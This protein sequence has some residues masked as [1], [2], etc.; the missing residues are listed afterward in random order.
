MGETS[1]SKWPFTSWLIQIGVILTTYYPWDD[2]PS[3]QQRREGPTH[4]TPFHGFHGGNSYCWWKKSIRRSPVEV[5]RLSHF[6][7]G[8]STIPGGCLGLLK[9]QPYH[10]DLQ[11]PGQR[12]STTLWNSLHDR[13]GPNSGLQIHPRRLTAGTWKWWALEDDFPLPGGP[14]SQVPC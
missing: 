1:P 6:L 11:I 10:F 8:F 2:P 3:S 12:S 5:G 14:Y 7:Q 9:H 13:S 4:S